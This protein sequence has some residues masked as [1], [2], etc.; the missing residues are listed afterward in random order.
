MQKYKT[1]IIDKE[2]NKIYLK[3]VKG[4]SWNL[5]EFKIFIHRL[6]GIWY[7][8]DKQTGLSI[9]CGITIYQVKEAT[10]QKLNKFIEK[11]KTKEYNDYKIRYNELLKKEE[12]ENGIC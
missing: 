12:K 8:V 4:Y 10:Y 6:R 11:T 2:E 5:E 7:A 3:E 1:L 9:A